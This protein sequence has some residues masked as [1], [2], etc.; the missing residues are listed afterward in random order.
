[1]E[2]AF[3]SKELRVLCLRAD[4][5]TAVLGAEQAAQLR[6]RL[7]DMRAAKCALD[8]IAGMPEIATDFDGTEC[9]RYRL[10]SDMHLLVRA[11]HRTLPKLPSGA[12]DWARVTRIKIT[13]VGVVNADHH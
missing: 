5:A 1:M 2:L 9:R 12:I 10:G 7:A 6:H 8:V 4:H 11:N 13:H 3:A